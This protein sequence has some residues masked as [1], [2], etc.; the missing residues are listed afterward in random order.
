LFTNKNSERFELK[1]DLYD[2]SGNFIIQMNDGNMLNNIQ[3]NKDIYDAHGNKIMRFDYDQK[4]MFILEG[5]NETWLY[6]YSDFLAYYP[7]GNVDKTRELY[8]NVSPVM[9]GDI[10][11]N[12]T[13]SCYGAYQYNY[14]ED[15][16]RSHKL[17]R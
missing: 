3:E 13:E 7:T 8:P 17:F 11:V 12:F 14:S 4:K 16:W 2:A 6:D 9:S 5:N 1:I 15:G 10:S